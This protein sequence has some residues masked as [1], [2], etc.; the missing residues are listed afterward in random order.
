MSTFYHTLTFRSSLLPCLCLKA[1]GTPSGVEEQWQ[2][3]D[4]QRCETQ[5]PRVFVGCCCLCVPR[6]VKFSLLWTICKFMSFLFYFVSS[7]SSLFL[8][9]FLSRFPQSHL[10]SLT[11]QRQA[12]PPSSTFTS[13]DCA[14]PR[15]SSHGQVG[16]PW[17]WSV[18]A[19]RSFTAF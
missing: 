4:V 19:S 7:V 16:I 17:R 13:A 1:E 15:C 18:D 6:Q 10:F 3:S 8:N 9:Y 5:P 12:H 14:G 2:H 11:L